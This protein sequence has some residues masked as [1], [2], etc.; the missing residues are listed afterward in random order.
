MSDKLFLTYTFMQQQVSYEEKWKK[1]LFHTVT[2][3]YIV[4][5]D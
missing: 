3:L 2:L 4:I 1:M 5:L